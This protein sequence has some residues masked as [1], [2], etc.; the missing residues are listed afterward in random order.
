MKKADE[1]PITPADCCAEA[2]TCPLSHVEAGT[3]V[4]IKQL[5]AQPN[6]IDRLREMGL[7]E[8]QRIRLISRHPSL[9]CQVCNARV[10]LSQDLAKAILVEPL[11]KVR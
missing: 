7:G 5:T 10:A 9:I 4:C 3:V 1:S 11:S 8:Q 2:A 6:V